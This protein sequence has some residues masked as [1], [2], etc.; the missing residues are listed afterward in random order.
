MAAPGAL[1]LDR[2]AFLQGAIAADF[3]RC[4]GRPVAPALRSKTTATEIVSVEVEL[5]D[6]SDRL[7]AECVREAVWD[8]VLPTAFYERWNTWTVYL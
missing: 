6:H 8:L 7:L 4:G 5:R 1:A 2:D 3:R